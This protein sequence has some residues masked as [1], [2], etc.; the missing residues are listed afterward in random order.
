MAPFLHIWAFDICSQ[1]RAYCK[2]TFPFSHPFT[3]G[4]TA[5]FV[6]VYFFRGLSKPNEIFYFGAIYGFE[7]MIFWSQGLSLSKLHHRPHKGTTRCVMSLAW[8]GFEPVIAQI[9]I[10]HSVE[11]V[12]NFS[13]SYMDILSGKIVFVRRTSIAKV[14]LV[15]TKNIPV[16]NWYE[17][18]G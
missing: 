14:L 17:F 18:A 7:P 13:E 1:H 10:Q 11:D 2:V 6:K 12:I 9:R 16:L 4:W 8:A 5:S 3:G 15:L